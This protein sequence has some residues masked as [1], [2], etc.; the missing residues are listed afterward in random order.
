MVVTFK[1]TH[2]RLH[3]LGL[4]L[5]GFVII[6]Q[7]WIHLFVFLARTLFLSHLLGRHVLVIGLLLLF[8]A[9]WVLIQNFFLVKVDFDNILN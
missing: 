1:S 2:D 8:G 6:L 3:H 4:L 7:D 9:I 5:E